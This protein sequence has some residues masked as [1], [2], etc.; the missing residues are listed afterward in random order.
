MTPTA[1]RCSHRKKINVRTGGDSKL[2]ARLETSN[3]V[4]S[5]ADDQDMKFRK[6][7]IIKNYDVFGALYNSSIMTARVRTRRPISKPNQ[8]KYWTCVRWR[9]FQTH[10][11]NPSPGTRKTGYAPDTVSHCSRRW[12]S[13]NPTRVRQFEFYGTESE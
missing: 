5:S 7:P 13:S 3:P 1:R 12:T 6:C 11:R 4:T 9:R 8:I 10:L 2:T